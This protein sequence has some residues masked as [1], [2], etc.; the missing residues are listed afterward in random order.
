MFRLV[1]NDLL[2]R[3][4]YLKYKKKYL[5][6][7][8]TQKGGF[9]PITEI[10]KQISPMY[11][12][13]GNYQQYGDLLLSIIEKELLSRN[14]TKF[15]ASGTTKLVYDTAN[16]QSVVKVVITNESLFDRF[17]KE[18]IEMMNNKNC[19]IPTNI[20]IFS[21]N[22]KNID[23]MTNINYDIGT[24]CV[25][26]WNEEKALVT[27]LEKFPKEVMDEAKVWYAITK[28]EL[29]QKNFTDLGTV[30]VGYFKTEPHFRWIDVQPKA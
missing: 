21:K 5:E 20:V 13:G 27:D 15:L 28:Q 18:P 8:Y 7:K 1:E 24:Y 10:I 11:Y 2:F 9:L 30:N 16:N 14:V 3:K 12:F 19:N 25:I 17:I 6:L 22:N 26:I 4:K 23:N 29:E